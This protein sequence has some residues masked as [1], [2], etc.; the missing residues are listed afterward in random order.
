MGT[1]TG[2]ISRKALILIGAVM[3]ILSTIISYSIFHHNETAAPDKKPP[4]QNARVP[5]SAFNA[6]ENMPAGANPS[7]VGSEPSLL[8]SQDLTEKS[9]PEAK[10]PVKTAESQPKAEAAVPKSKTS[11]EKNALEAKTASGKEKEAKAEPKKT[12]TAEIAPGKAEETKPAPVKAESEA[13]AIT[14]PPKTEEAAKVPAGKKPGQL[15]LQIGEYPDLKSMLK[16]MNRVKELGFETAFEEK[17]TQG[18]KKEYFLVMEKEFTEGEAKAESLKMKVAHKLETSINPGPEGKSQVWIGP[19]SKLTEAVK[20]TKML[21]EEGT[22]TR[23]E[24]KKKSGKKVYL[25][26]G[27]FSDKMGMI[28]A[29][30]VLKNNGFS[31]ETPALP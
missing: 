12:E 7:G 8:P 22:D 20:T 9:A 11:P 17:E 21:K 26:A 30:A 6:E 15:R 23:V 14:T 10:P 2:G 16:D 3:F 18:G 24:S 25:F 1:N 29:K 31:P 5:E 28:K 4:V 27:P 13:V 19:F